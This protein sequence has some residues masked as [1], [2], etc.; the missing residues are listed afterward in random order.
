MRQ[1]ILFGAGEIGKN[2]LK[3]FGKDRVVCFCDNNSHK[4]NDSVDGVPIIPATDLS[5]FVGDEITIV[6]TTTKLR[7]VVEISRQL[8]SLGYDF[9][10]FE[11]AGEEILREDIGDYCALN[12]R[13]SFEYDRNCEYLVSVDRYKRAGNADSYFW[14]DLWAAK[15]ISLRTVCP[16]TRPWKSRIRLTKEPFLTIFWPITWW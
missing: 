9:K 6:I 7:N 15:K 10:L 5:K 8:W 14:Q 3:F 4:K 2:A 13:D 11:E 16:A 1:Y 12:Q